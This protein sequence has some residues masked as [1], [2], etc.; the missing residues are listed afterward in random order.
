MRKVLV[1]SNMYPSKSFPHYGIF[2]K[3]TNIL[4]QRSG[5]KVFN[6]VMKKTDNKVL[7]LLRY[8]YFLLRSVI[9]LN[10]KK[11]DV[12]YVHYP[13]FSA[14]PLRFW[15]RNK[16]K[17]II[18]I[19]G[20]DLVAEEEKDIF[21]MK[22]TDFAV[23]ESDYVVVPSN[24]FRKEFI[25][26]YKDYNFDKLFV[27]PSGGVNKEIFF[28][29]DKC[30]AA[31]KLNLDPKYKYISFV[32][33]IEINKGWDLFIE[34]AKSLK[35]I[36]PNYRYIIVGAGT[37]EKDLENMIKKLNLEDLIIKYDYLPHEELRNIF[38]VSEFFC[39][40]TMRK[41]ES[42]GLVGLEAM[43]CQSIVI[44]SSGTGPS[45]YVQDNYNGF[46]LKENTSEE[47]SRNILKV[48][49]MSEKAKRDVQ[50]KAEKT[51]IKYSLD[52]TAKS[53]EQFIDSI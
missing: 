3:N 52:N 23:A 40:P 16:C 7:K 25:K 49:S 8:M 50:E 30:L 34:S 15:H 11:F 51:T 41:S 13:A 37:Q 19:H 20:N 42:L 12:V 26:K 2:V 10:F 53:F 24:Y 46:L 35:K 22:N 28:P 44:A 17:V 38:N 31:G 48:V 36:L 4:L 47:I 32:S 43:A 18:N 33:R 9:M 39:F 21:F 29:E 45:S 6:S 1:L 27:F 14:I 5:Y